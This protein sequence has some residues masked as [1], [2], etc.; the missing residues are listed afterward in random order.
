MMRR[1]RDHR[2]D[3]DI[4][5][6]SVFCMTLFVLCAMWARFAPIAATLVALGAF[7]TLCA[8]DYL[9]YPNLLDQGPI[10]KLI[11]GVVLIRGLMNAVMS[12]TI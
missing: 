1:G 10:Y 3:V 6:T 7:A 9:T 12:K 11:L 5:L 2:L 4:V 8:R